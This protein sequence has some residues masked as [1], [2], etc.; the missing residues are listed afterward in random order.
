MLWLMVVVGAFCAGI[1]TERQL[2]RMR[3]AEAIQD[4]SHENLS[5]HQAERRTRRV[6]QPDDVDGNGDQKAGDRD[7]CPR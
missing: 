5:G 1:V 3:S 7:P 4:T 6:N 2:Q